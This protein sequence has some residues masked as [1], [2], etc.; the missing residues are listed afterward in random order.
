MDSDY[1][2]AGL[3]GSNFG[4]GGAPAIFGNP[5]RIGDYGPRYYGSHENLFGGMAMADAAGL[6]VGDIAIGAIYLGGG[7]IEVTELPDPT[8][9][10][11]PSNRPYSIGER[12]HHDLA[13]GAG[14]SF[15]LRD[16][17]E[18]GAS[19]G[20]I[21]RRLIES[22]AFG[23]F[24]SVGFDWVAAQGLHLGALS[25]ASF[26]SWDTGKSEFGLPDFLLGGSYE[27]DLGSDFSGKIVAEGRFT[28]AAALEFSAGAEVS[29]NSLVA[30]RF[31]TDNGGLT[32]GADISILPNIRVGAAMTTHSELPLSYRFGVNIYNSRGVGD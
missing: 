28:D 29:Y 2:S 13:F 17:I 16:G 10:V 30:L 19:G 8:E 25:S 22:D 3:G 24:G 6:L 11:G 27:R 18:L 5:A 31:G 7:G 1:I 12:G 14:Y 32:A 26:V 15:R 23:G 4:I 20:G 21:F 9:P